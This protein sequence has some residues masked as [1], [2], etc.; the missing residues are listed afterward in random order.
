MNM[1]AELD[2]KAGNKIRDFLF[3]DLDSANLVQY[4]KDIFK[5]VLDRAR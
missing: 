1:A 5:K 2:D 4:E 3:Y